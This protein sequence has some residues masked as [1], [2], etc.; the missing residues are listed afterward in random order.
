MRCISFFVIEFSSWLDC[1]N[2]TVLVIDHLLVD[3]EMCD[4][5][6]CVRNEFVFGT[7]NHGGV[8]CLREVVVCCHIRFAIFHVDAV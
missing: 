1:R 4:F 6:M 7:R 2:G 3:S 5:G 8:T